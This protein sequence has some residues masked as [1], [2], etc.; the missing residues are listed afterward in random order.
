MQVFRNKSK[1]FLIAS[2]LT[3]STQSGTGAISFPDAAI[4]ACRFRDRS[5]CFSYASF[6]IFLIVVRIFAVRIFAVS[7]MVWIGPRAVQK[8]KESVSIFLT[9]SWVVGLWGVGG[10]PVPRPGVL[11]PLR[12]ELPS[13]VAPIKAVSDV[14]RPLPSKDMRAFP[15]RRDLL[16][17]SS[18][19]VYTA[20]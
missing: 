20:F 4:S 14:L 8:K 17:K 6:D 9:S 15:P 18:A 5:F 11:P 3:G 12:A 13:G 16:R 1:S 19:F 10:G 7:V 2:R